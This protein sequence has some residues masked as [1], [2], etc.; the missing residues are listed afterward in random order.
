MPDGGSGPLRD[1]TYDGQRQTL[2]DGTTILKSGLGQLL[3]GHVGSDDYMSSPYEWVGWSRDDQG[4]Q[5]SNLK[6]ILQN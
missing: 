1:D 6:V 2:D 4:T 3:D 5:K